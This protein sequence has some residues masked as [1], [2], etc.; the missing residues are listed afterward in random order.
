VPA[1]AQLSVAASM[2]TVLLRPVVVDLANA[3]GVPAGAVRAE[4]PSLA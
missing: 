3:A 1:A 4:L 2:I